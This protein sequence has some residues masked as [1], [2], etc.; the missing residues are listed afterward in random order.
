MACYIM[1]MLFFQV[2]IFQISFAL[3][4][5]IVMCLVIVFAV[6]IRLTN[7]TFIT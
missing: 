7:A 6:L 2:L 5:D 1:P 4:T 3:L